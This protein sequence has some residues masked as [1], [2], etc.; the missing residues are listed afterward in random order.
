MNSNTDFFY[1]QVNSKSSI[2]FP[3][4]TPSSFTVELPNE[5]ELKGE[6]EVA[7]THAELPATERIFRNS[8]SYYPV[9]ENKVCFFV[10]TID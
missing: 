10:I 6:W 9:K 2:S 1:L 8:L 4:N 5:I 7:L 3:T